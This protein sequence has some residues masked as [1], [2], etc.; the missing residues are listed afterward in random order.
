MIVLLSLQPRRIRVNHVNDYWKRLVHPNSINIFQKIIDEHPVIISIS[1]ERKSKHGDFRSFNSK[2][3]DRISVNGSLSQD[4]FM[5]TLIH[6]LAHK[7]TWDKFKH[8]VQPHGK[9]WKLNMFLLFKSF[10]NQNLFSEE[11]ERAIKIYQH[12]W[13]AVGSRMPQL[14]LAL[15]PHLE[16]LKLLKDLDI[17]TR[18]STENGRQFVKKK[19]LRS[20]CLCICCKTGDLYKIHQLATVVENI[21]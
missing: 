5:I 4:A 18:F 1:G 17:D 19:Q 3:K 8:K 2:R 15:N 10:I 20:Y 13:K 11:V 9:E 16:S 6:E 12:D 21:E 14:Y 7:I